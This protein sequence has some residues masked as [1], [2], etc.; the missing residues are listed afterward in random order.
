M[1]LFFLPIFLA[2][3]VS[4]SLAQT[5]TVPAG[6]GTTAD[7]YQ[8]SSLENLYWLSQNS[9]AWADTF[10]QTAD[11]DASETS[12][13][14][15]D[16]GFTPI[17][18]FQ[19]SYDGQ[20]HVIDGLTILRPD[21]DNL[22]LFG[23][24]SGIVSNLGVTGVSI[25]GSSAVGALA[26]QLSQGRIDNSFSTGSVTAST[27]AVGGLAGSVFWTSQISDSHSG[28]VV[29]SGTGRAGGLAGSVMMDDTIS[30]SYA[31]G[32]V[33]GGAGYVGGLLGYVEMDILV[34][35][36]HATGVVSGGSNYVGG[37]VG[38]AS[39]V[40]IKGSHATGSVTGDSS[41][42]GLMGYGGSDKI[43]SSYARG[44]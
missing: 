12:G 17:S 4:L 21:A 33:T 31:T 6:S 28:V 22:G 41:V 18:L 7:P 32:D 20:G 13:W 39:G 35:D 27:G 24:L 3:F 43:S 10:V 44:T 34:Q 23:Q 40:E 19:G 29:M 30:N 38:Y 16:S 5:A 42:G 11:I 1:K 9:T 26:G 36:C 15:N 37:L 2:G 14:D 25:S 8:I